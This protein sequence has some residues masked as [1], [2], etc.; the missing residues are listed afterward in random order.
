MI[1]YA[2]FLARKA[3]LAETAGI[4]VSASDI[5]PMLHPWQNE[6]V[7]WAVRTAARHSGPT[8]AW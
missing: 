5:H 6:L 1:T 8:P 7:Q 2:E 4:A 3:Q